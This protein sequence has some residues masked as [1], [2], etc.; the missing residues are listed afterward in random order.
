MNPTREYKMEK[1][2]V[3]E[4]FY[5]AIGNANALRRGVLEASKKIIE[6]LH[7]FE[8]FKRIRAH[9]IRAT[10]E[11]ILLVREVNE[12]SAQIKIDMPKIRLPTAAGKA[13]GKKKKEKVVEDV[14]LGSD[15][16]LRK[17]ETAIRQI[18]SRLTNLR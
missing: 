12:I 2:D 11:L 5:V 10:E 13:A 16:E 17:L 18:E 15:E 9:R 4:I 7:R 1:D 8:K 6:S 14:K 3:S